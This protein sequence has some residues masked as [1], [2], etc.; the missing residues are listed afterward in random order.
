MSH[1]SWARPWRRWSS[2]LR[3]TGAPAFL[4]DLKR[5]SKGRR[6]MLCPCTENGLFMTLAHAAGSER[7]QAYMRR[8]GSGQLC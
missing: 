4:P 5:G 8:E 2:P 6:E 1:R 7:D 3:E